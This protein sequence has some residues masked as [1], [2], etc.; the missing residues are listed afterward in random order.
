MSMIIELSYNIIPHTSQLNQALSNSCAC[1]CG[2]SSALLPDEFVIESMITHK[3]QLR[4]WNEC[5]AR[6][7]AMLCKRAFSHNNN[8]NNLT[9]AIAVAAVK[10]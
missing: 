3:S 8:N 9:H 10:F 4:V 2:C 7:Q 1:T 5:R 6:L